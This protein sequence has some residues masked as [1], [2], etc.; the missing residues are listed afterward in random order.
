MGQRFRLGVAF[1][2]GLG[3]WGEVISFLMK[4]FRV[5]I[6]GVVVGWS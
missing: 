4:T 3:L 6:L 1:G 5:G 2:H